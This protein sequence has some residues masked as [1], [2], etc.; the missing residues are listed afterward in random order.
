MTFW[1]S[2]I[3][4]YV[5]PWHSEIST[6]VEHS[7]S[8]ILSTCGFILWSWS[9]S[10]RFCDHNFSSLL[11]VCWWGTCSAVEYWLTCT[12]A[13]LAFYTPSLFTA[14]WVLQVC[15]SSCM[16]P[17]KKI[18]REDYSSGKNTLALSPFHMTPFLLWCMLW[19]H[20]ACHALQLPLITFVISS[21][22]F[23]LHPLNTL[24]LT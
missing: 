5:L 4:H 23:K 15:L 24:P 10:T 16:S 22:T 8:S 9:N 12:S 3:I 6:V 11:L 13:L 21:C 2:V 7:R 18:F 20:V 1:D 19:L 14:K 17:L